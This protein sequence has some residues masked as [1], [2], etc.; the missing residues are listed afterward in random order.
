VGAERFALL[1]ERDFFGSPRDARTWRYH[2]V[3]EAGHPVF[4]KFP[5]FNL[6]TAA[7]KVELRGE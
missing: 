3:Y 7:F 6:F 2:L 4:F 1:A 5:F